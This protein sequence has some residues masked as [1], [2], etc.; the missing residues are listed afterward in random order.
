MRSA[1]L[2]TI[3]RCTH[4]WSLMPSRSAV[5]CCDV[6]ARLQ[7]LVRV[8]PAQQA[9]ELA[10]RSLGACHAHRGDQLPRVSGEGSAIGG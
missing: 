10:L 8:G 3:C 1:M 9:G 6:P 5:T 2:S 7:L 4:E